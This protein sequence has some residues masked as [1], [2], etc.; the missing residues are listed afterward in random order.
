MAPRTTALFV[1]LSCQLLGPELYHK[2]STVTGTRSREQS[3]QNGGASVPV[4]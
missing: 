2:E 4:S 3:V 1:P